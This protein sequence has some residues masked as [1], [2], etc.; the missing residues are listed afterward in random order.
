[1]KILVLTAAPNSYATQSI[2]NAGKKR[3][4]K[5]IV[6]DPAYLY[7][8]VSDAVSGYDRIYDGYDQNFKPERMPAK[9]YDAI[10]PRIGTNLSYGSAVL[11]H[12]NNNLKIFSTQTATGIKTAADKLISLQKISQAKIR[13]PKTVLG[14]KAAHV[15][16]MIQQVGNL[17]AIAKGL[18]GSQGKT[19]FPLNDEYQSNVF[20][21]NFYQKRENLLLQKFI[22]G[23][24]KDIRAIVIDGK[25]VAAM[26]RSAAKGEL[27]SNIS[28]GGTGKKIDLSEDDQEICVKAAQS[29]GLEVAGVDIIKDPDGKTYVIEVN[30]NYGYHIEE[31]T[32]IDISTPLI[33]YCEKNAKTGNKTNQESTSAMYG[34]NGKAIELSL[35]AQG[36]YTYIIGNKKP[37]VFSKLAK[38]VKPKTNQKNKTET[39]V[40]GNDVKSLN[41]M[42][43]LKRK[44]G[45]L[46]I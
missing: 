24:A 16:W 12:L 37:N 34:I 40:Y 10:I 45:N 15:A 21:E 5:M 19:V 11:E 26:E 1:M 35:K 32:G 9:E 36:N 2:V 20:L 29:C 39:S 27:R 6:K 25:V 8:L 38:I 17:P 13:V 3:K 41:E 28:R 46:K 18:T 4:H 44:F 14:D 22:D 43:E 30:G 31:I 33:E 42:T 7:L 23:G